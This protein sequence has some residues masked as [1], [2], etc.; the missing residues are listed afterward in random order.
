MKLK[1][2]D[3]D[4]GEPV[5]EPED[6]D[7]IEAGM[8]IRVPHVT[9]PWVSNPVERSIERQMALSIVAQIGAELYRAGFEAGRVKMMQALGGNTS[10][11]IEVTEPEIIKALTKVGIL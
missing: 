3:S 1:T 2:F 7:P 9:G 11:N 10:R 6:A 4:T 5:Y 8:T